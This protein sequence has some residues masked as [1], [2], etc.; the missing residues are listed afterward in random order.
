MSG[1]D[2]EGHV[3][4]QAARRRSAAAGLDLERLRAEDPEKYR[5]LCAKRLAVVD[6]RL[7]GEAEAAT[8]SV[9][10]GFRI[11]EAE[12]AH[13]VLLLAFPEPGEQ[14]LAK[15]DDAL[16]GVAA[17][18][19]GRNAYFRIVNDSA[20]E[21]RELGIPVDPGDWR[22]QETMVGPFDDEAQARA[23]ASERIIGSERLTFDTVPLHGAWFCD[24]FRGDL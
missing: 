24:V 18:A 6:P 15:L 3:P 1:E 17:A 4:S 13:G 21:R 20:G 12:G 2:L 14:Q 8:A 11:Y 16:A 22:D 5:M 9:L 7:L 19:A 10:P 23:W